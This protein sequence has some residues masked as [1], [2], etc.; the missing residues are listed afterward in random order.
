MYETCTKVTN[1]QKLPLHQINFSHQL[2]YKN[3][4]LKVN[5]VV[6]SRPETSCIIFYVCHNIYHKFVFS[7]EY[8][9]SSK[10]KILSLGLIS[11]TTIWWPVSV[12]LSLS[13]QWLHNNCANARLL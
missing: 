10:V 13:D 4:N 12:Y 11:E 9:W 8:M 6:H 5:Q 1:Q 2:A 7:S 3:L